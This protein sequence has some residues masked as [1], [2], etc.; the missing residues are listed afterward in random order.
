MRTEMRQILS[1][2]GADEKSFADLFDLK[3]PPNGLTEIAYKMKP[4]ALLGLV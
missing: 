4:L 1:G 2:V 3:I